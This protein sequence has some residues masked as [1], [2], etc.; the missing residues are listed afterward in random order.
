MKKLALVLPALLLLAGCHIDKTI[1]VV[2]FKDMAGLILLMAI[3]VGIGGLYLWAYIMDWW[4][5]RRD[6][7][8]RENGN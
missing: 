2:R 6:R 7:K 1:L 4:E 8:R 3:L 5:A